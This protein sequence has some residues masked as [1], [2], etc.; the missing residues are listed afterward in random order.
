MRS[1][2]IAILLLPLFYRGVSAVEPEKVNVRKINFEGNHVFSNGSLRKL[3]ATHARG[4]FTSSR[5][6]PDVFDND[7][8]NIQK[9]YVENGY[10]EAAIARVKIDSVGNNFTI[11]VSIFEGKPTKVESISFIGNSV[12]TTKELMQSVPLKPGDPLKSALVRDSIAAIMTRYGEKGYL[13]VQITPDIKVNHEIHLAIA[14][15][16]IQE[17]DQYTVGEI[18]INNLKKTH[19]IVVTREFLFKKGDVL[20]YSNLLKTERNL[21]LAGLFNTV[22]I[23]PESYSSPDTT[24]KNIVVDLRERKA[25]EFDI[26]A[27]YATIDKF[28]GTLS[29]QDNNFLSAGRRAGFSGILSG[30][31]QNAKVNYSQFWTLGLRLRTDVNGIAEYDVEPGYDVRRIGGNI[32]F[33]RKISDYT[34]ALLS[35][36]LQK[37]RIT[38]IETVTIPQGLETGNLRTLELQG[39]YDNRNDLLNTT[40]GTYLDTTNDLVGTFLQG[41]NSYVS[42]LWTFKQFYQAADYAVLGTALQIG[43]K[44]IFTHPQI[45]ISELFYAGGPNALRGYA[46]QSVG[47]ADVNGVP[48]GGRALLVWNILEIRIRLYKIFGIAFFADAG[49]VWADPRH[50]RFSDIR[51]DAGF[52]PRIV[53]PI[54]VIRADIGYKI[55]RKKGESKSEFYFAMGQAF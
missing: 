27:G 24:K 20:N 31:S 30:K 38:N 32:S 11:D 33:S 9:F 25:G 39:S 34:T 48:L 10:L 46:Y 16:D 3:M 35:Y 43:A 1:I 22:Y 6:S 54:G 52:G 37:I 18:T 47:P 21:Y 2:S 28:R 49:T 14:T 5:Y 23:H 51:Y 19:E 53:T 26:G 15:F 13:S 4:L 45:P 8:Q 7:L 36:R 41:T 29:V 55:G 40:G 42:T 17:K 12:Y 44:G 50:V